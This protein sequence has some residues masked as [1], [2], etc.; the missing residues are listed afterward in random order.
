M[1]MEKASIFYSG[2]KKLS[3]MYAGGAGSHHMRFAATLHTS[4]L[5]FLAA[6]L[7]MYTVMALTT[8]HLISRI[9][10]TSISTQ[11][12]TLHCLLRLSDTLL[13]TATLLSLR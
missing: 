1:H 11:K 12:T 4:C 5:I 8:R 9:T 3:T 6:L 7:N 13:G 2:S 10:H